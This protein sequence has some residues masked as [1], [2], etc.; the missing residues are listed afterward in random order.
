ML[1]LCIP[2]WTIDLPSWG[3][4]PRLPTTYLFCHTKFQNLC[5]L[6]DCPQATLRTSLIFYVFSWSSLVVRV[7]SSC[8][9]FMVVSLRPFQVLPIICSHS[10]RMLLHLPGDPRLR[11]SFPPTNSV[12]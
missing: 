11:S 7:C 2:N 8:P 12:D 5:Q 4:E 3:P 6:G 9:H 1:E 10:G